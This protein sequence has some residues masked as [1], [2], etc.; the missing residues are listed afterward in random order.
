M[1]DAA[2]ETS[3]AQRDGFNGTEGMRSS[4]AG[5]A[6]TTG[7]EIRKVVTTEFQGSWEVRVAPYGRGREYLRYFCRSGLR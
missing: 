1:V 6:G 3:R 7:I 2:T 4:G 5:A